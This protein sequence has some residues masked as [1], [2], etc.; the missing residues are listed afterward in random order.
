MTSKLAELVNATPVELLAGDLQ[1]VAASL[2]RAQKALEA[3]TGGR[4]TWLDAPVAIAKE[5]ARAQPNHVRESADP[6]HVVICLEGGIITST[7]SAEPL[8]VS[9]IDYDTEDCVDDDDL[10]AIPQ[11]DGTVAAG[12]TAIVQATVDPAR[13]TELIAAVAFPWPMCRDDMRP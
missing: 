1:I 10:S 5:R 13:A 9:V 2:E 6:P 11:G 7:L 8:T 12:Y 4:Q 3:A